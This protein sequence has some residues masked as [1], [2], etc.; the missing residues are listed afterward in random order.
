[1][2][3]QKLKIFLILYIYKEMAEMERDLQQRA[4]DAA[5]DTAEAPTIAAANDAEGEGGGWMGRLE[6]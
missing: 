6:R 4:D 1:M 2:L 3:F 5:A